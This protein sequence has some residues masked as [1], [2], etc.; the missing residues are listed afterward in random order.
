MRKGI[1]VEIDNL[2]GNKTNQVMINE[3]N[4]VAIKESVRP[5]VMKNG[6]I[7]WVDDRTAENIQQILLTQTGHTFIK[8]RELGITI[9]TAEIVGIYTNS[10]YNDLIRLKQGMFKC[11]YAQWHG[12]KDECQCEAKAK[13]KFEESMQQ[14]RDERDNKPLS[15]E[16]IEKRKE[17]LLRQS[18]EW[19]LQGSPVGRAIFLTGNKDGKKIRRSVII[20][21]EAKNGSAVLEGLE[22]NELQ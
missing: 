3:R 8:I 15:D 20:E 9:N 2:W 17:M 13:R 21:W 4:T 18:E 22:I 1:E 19:A 10:E 7:H 12:R 16:E 14:A 11:S 6:L 5:I